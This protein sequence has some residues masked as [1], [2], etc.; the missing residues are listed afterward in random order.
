MKEYPNPNYLL[1]IRCIKSESEPE[2]AKHIDSG[3]L[4]TVNHIVSIVFLPCIP[5]HPWPPSP[6]SS[7]DLFRA[8]D[9]HEA[10]LATLHM[11]N[12]FVTSSKDEIESIEN[13]PHEI[14]E[15]QTVYFVSRA[16]YEGLDAEISALKRRPL[17][18]D[19]YGVYRDL[20]LSDLGDSLLRSFLTR[21]LPRSAALSDYDRNILCLGPLQDYV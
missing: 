6:L 9:R 17:S 14:Q 20:F 13:L 21:D 11:S 15:V 3:W 2:I 19:D 1:D 7:N 18:L 5:T 8:R 16:H 12:Q 4:L 10:A